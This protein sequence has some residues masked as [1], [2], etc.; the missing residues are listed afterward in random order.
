MDTV[1]KGQIIRDIIHEVQIHFEQFKEALPLRIIAIK[2]GKRS[3][4]VGGVKSL[5]FE[6]EADGTFQ[7]RRN[8]TGGIYVLPNS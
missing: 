6:C 4:D 1:K 2:Y 3:L 8:R 5:V 7:I